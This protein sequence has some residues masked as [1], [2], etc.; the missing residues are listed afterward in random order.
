MAR[1]RTQKAV[2]QRI[3]L[4]YFQRAHPLRTGRKLLMALFFIGAIIAVAL[5]SVGGDG[6]LHNPGALTRA[7]A[8]WEHDCRACH[9]GG[10]PGV[11]NAGTGKGFA[12]TVSDAACLS[13]HDG[14]AHAFNQ[15]PDTLAKW[16]SGSE[17]A[18]VHSTA[19]DCVSCHVEHRGEALLIN[20]NPTSCTSCHAD[21]KAHSDK[22]PVVANRAAEFTVADHPPF[23]RK[24]LKDGKLFDPTVI[25]FNHEKH[26]KVAG[27]KDNCI[28]CHAGFDPQLTAS[29]PGPNVPPPYLTGKDRPVA[30]NN[31]DDRAYLAPVS[32]EK[33]CVG[34]HAIELPV[35]GVRLDVP[36]RELAELRPF[37]ASLPETLAGELARMTPEARQKELV[38][39]VVTGRPPR[40][41]RERKVLTETEWVE[42]R[43]K[44]LAAAID[45]AGGTAPAFAAIK[46]ALP[47]P[48]TQP[49]PSAA[50][51]PSLVEH[52]VTF[53]V[54]ANCNYCH[55]VKGVVPAVAKAAAVPAT[56]PAAP[57]PAEDPAALALAYT[58][59][60]GIP[61]APRK[62]FTGSK[63]DHHAHRSVACLDCHT[64]APGSSLTSDIL[65][66]NIDEGVNGA[67]CVSCHQPSRPSAPL[68]GSQV[69]HAPADCT[70][71]HSFHDDLLSRPPTGSIDPR[72]GKPRLT[73]PHLAMPATR[74]VAD[75]Q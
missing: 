32:Y 47:A 74:P 75:G 58:V 67:S 27:L 36:H 13:C 1:V 39:E 44:D 28:S 48:S 21:L 73:S 55:E 17:L 12:K 43:L 9:D 46:R 24:L 52:F 60:T 33:H 70:T 16:P 61:A 29:A 37:F 62:W 57:R 71:C 51:D 15:K 14:A 40:Q 56:L 26:N 72:T 18:K 20:A 64:K 11:D 59:R 25:K 41:R 50:P 2:S 66:P 49:A 4:S 53:G 10:G 54:G 38:T 3:D 35:G 22:P 23:G 30:W 8:A 68:F 31:G 69:R 19:K 6:R 42:A 65:S 5:L 45:R 34:C 7:H 63:F